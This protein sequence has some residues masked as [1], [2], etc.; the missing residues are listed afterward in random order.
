MRDGERFKPGCFR[1][2][3]VAVVGMGRSNRALTRYLVKEGADVTCFD[4]KAARE[5]GPAYAELTALGVKWSLGAG[6]LSTLPDFK[7]VFLTPGMKKNLPEIALARENGAVITCEIALFLDRS[8]CPVIAVTG[9]SGKTTACTLAGLMLRESLPGKMVLIGGNIG[10]VLIEQVDDI[11]EDAVVVLELSSFQLE[12]LTR[13]PHVSAILN[14][15]PNHLDIHDSFHEYVEAKKNVFRFQSADN[16]CFLNLD[17]DVTRSLAPLCPGGLG[18]F[19]LDPGKIEGEFDRLREGSP[20]AW[21]GG[22]ELYVAP[23]PLADA[24]GSGD[25]S[26]QPYRRVARRGDMPVPGDHNVSNALAAAL[27]SV[28]AGATPEG[29]GRALRTFKGVE[30][31]IEFVRELRGVSYYND[32][33][34]TSPDRT[35]ALLDAVQ[36]PLV[37]ILGGYDKGLSF[38]P[39]ARKIVSRGCGVVTIGKAATLIE[40]ALAKAETDLSAASG[41]PSSERVAEEPALRVARASSLDEAVILATEMARAIPG[42]SV[43]LSPACASYDMFRDYEE[44]GRLF[45]EAVGRLG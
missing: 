36:G 35:E 8:R 38:E 21:A 41:E 39:L 37:L 26:G 20:V 22:E 16:W 32:S 40:E 12:L 13:S 9:S 18:F 30:H 42:S 10:S 44:R 1:G 25:W 28:A 45:K 11:P 15:R 43:A 23:G 5:L 6:Y 34:A 31:R 33:I 14:L 27:L 17:D 2:A 3:R 19:T 4:Q 29:I 7:W 24:A